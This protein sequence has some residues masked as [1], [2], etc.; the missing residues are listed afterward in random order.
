MGKKTVYEALDAQRIRVHLSPV[1]QNICGSVHVHASID[2]TNTWMV[3][4][5]RSGGVRSG[6]IC[7]AEAQTAGRG[8]RGRTWNSPASGNLYFSL[9]WQLL[10]PELN[11]GPVTLALGVAAADAIRQFSECEIGLKWPND[12]YF[13]ARKLGGI[14]VER[15]VIEAGTFWVI[16][17]G[18][19]LSVEG[20]SQTTNPPAAG[21]VNL[22]PDAKANRNRIAAALIDRLLQACLRYEE[23]GFEEVRARWARYDLTQGKEL[24]LFMADGRRLNGIGA[25]ID[26][27]GRLCVLCEGSQM[28]L[29]AGE[30]S[31]RIS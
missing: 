22:W 6:D 13:Q 4:G 31:L 19:N 14:L 28:Y 17:I 8:R 27:K 29:D 25:G 24:D 7:L 26:E 23:V 21:L 10:H 15:T 2:S 20:L 12:L 3:N 9:A 1:G 18:L 16:G 11:P 30:V 5:L